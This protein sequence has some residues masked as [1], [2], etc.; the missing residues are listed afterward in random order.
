MKKM[1]ISLRGKHNVCGHSLSLLTRASIS[2]CLLQLLL[3][4]T[5]CYFAILLLL[6][7]WCFYEHNKIQGK[8]LQCPIRILYLKVHICYVMFLLPKIKCHK[9]LVPSDSTCLYLVPPKGNLHVVSTNFYLA[10][11]RRWLRGWSVLCAVIRTWL[12]PALTETLT[13][14]HAEE[15]RRQRQPL[16]ASWLAV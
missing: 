8:H 15:L 4:I 9:V 16:G 5:N 12:S 2:S 7:L 6:M 11:L 1:E 3:T 10:W 14:L 13:K